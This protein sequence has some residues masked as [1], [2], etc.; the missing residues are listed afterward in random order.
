[1]PRYAAFLRGMNL[2]GR[3][4]TNT[5]LCRHVAALGFEDVAT[6][7]ASGNVVVSTADRATPAA[8]AR[9]IEEGL[10]QALSYAVPT[11]VRTAAQ[12]QAISAHQPFDAAAIAASRGKLQIALLECAPNAAAVKAVL[13]L[14][15]DD[16]RL[17]IH[18][19]ELYW[20]PSG[21]MSDSALDLKAIEAALGPTTTRTKGT[22][23]Q[24]AQKFF[25]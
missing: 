5:D 11:Y 25:A 6:F 7:R 15:S 16:D 21:G 14:H 20:L 24:V 8:V 17:A 18:D 23:D 1:M 22:I 3:R 13:A 10:A 19:Q 9:R 2:G 4:I 12:M